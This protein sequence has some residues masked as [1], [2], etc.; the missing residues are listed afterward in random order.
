MNSVWLLAAPVMLTLAACLRFIP[1]LSI[2]RWR[3]ISAAVCQGLVLVPLI[4][5]A[6]LFQSGSTPVEGDWL[7]I[8]PFRLVML[9]LVLGLG[10]ILLRF[11]R[12]YMAGEA[13]FDRYYGWLLLTL[14]SVSV[15]LMANHLLVFWFGW[16]A[17]SLSLHQLL[18]LYPERPRAALAAHKK[19]FWRE[20]PSRRCC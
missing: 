14:A 12:H 5:G 4:V 18:M 13:C 16:L 3:G 9:T 1:A 2:A 19:L 10:A 15:T 17:I 11:S 7:A 8:S 6:V 20:L